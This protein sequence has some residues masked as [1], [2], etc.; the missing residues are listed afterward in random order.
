[1]NAKRPARDSSF[2]EKTTINW[3]SAEEIPTTLI[4]EVRRQLSSGLFGFL[5][6]PL[7]LLLM[8]SWSFERLKRS[9]YESK[10]TLK[11]IFKKVSSD[12]LTIKRFQFQLI[13]LSQSELKYKYQTRLSLL[14]NQHPSWFLWSSMLWLSVCPNTNLRSIS[15]TTSLCCSTPVWNSQISIFFKVP[16]WATKTRFLFTC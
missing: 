5:T 3:S 9:R 16:L 8:K 13:R 15:K 12:F 6:S 11:T 2:Q 7:R 10:K 1:M 4:L 14:P